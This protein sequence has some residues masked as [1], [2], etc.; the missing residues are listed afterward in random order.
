MHNYVV[1]LRKEQKQC[2]NKTNDWKPECLKK[3]SNLG[4]HAVEL[5]FVVDMRLPRNVA[6]YST[7]QIPCIESNSK[8]FE[9]ITVFPVK[10]WMPE[11]I[12]GMFIVSR[13]IRCEMKPQKITDKPQNG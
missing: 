5:I 8:G 4:L 12:S 11:K 1:C 6:L 9:D 3:H 10:P 2:G 13:P 7:H